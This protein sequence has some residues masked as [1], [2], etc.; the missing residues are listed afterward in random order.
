MYPHA[1][2]LSWCCFVTFWWIA[3]MVDKLPARWPFSWTQSSAQSLS[4][5]GQYQRD[6]N[7]KSL[8][9]CTMCLTLF[10][11]FPHVSR[12]AFALSSDE[13][14]LWATA[15][16]GQLQF[17]SSS[18]SYTQTKDMRWNWAFTVFTENPSGFIIFKSSL[19]R[20]SLLLLLLENTIY[21][22]AGSWDTVKPIY[23]LHKQK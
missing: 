17:S 14:Q 16:V 8:T 7:C 10:L 18:L 23:K 1:N 9:F 12:C 20:I 2:K 6:T 19:R 11:I 21:K 22:N 4:D 5:D 15:H 3:W 13:S